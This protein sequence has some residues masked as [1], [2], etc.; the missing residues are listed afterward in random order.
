MPCKHVLPLRLRRGHQN[1]RPRS[2]LCPLAVGIVLYSLYVVRIG[3]DF[4]SGRFFTAPFVLGLS[5]LATL[6]VKRPLALVAMAVTAAAFGFLSP[7]PTTSLASA[8]TE[9]RGCWLHGDGIVDERLFYSRSAGY[10]RR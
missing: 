3:G 6:R 1:G 4:M 5:I 2:T 7:S 10:P 8:G 9:D